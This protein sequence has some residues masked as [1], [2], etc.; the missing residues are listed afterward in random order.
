MKHTKVFLFASLVG[1]S[2]LL[3]GCEF[4]LA[5]DIT[6]PPG[7]T[8][9][10]TTS[11][12]QP[13]SSGPN[14]PLVAPNPASG[15]AIY[16]EK[17]L[18]CHGELGMGD[19]SQAAQLPNPVPAIGREDVAQQAK[20]SDWYNIVTNGNL[21]RYMPPF[22][23]LS[24][25]QRWDV[26][27]YVLSLS[28]G[29]NDLSTGAAV[30]AENCAACHGPDGQGDGRE[31]AGL[32][33]PPTSFTDQEIMAQL[34]ASDLYQSVKNGSGEMPAFGD[35]LSDDQIWAV[36]EYLRSLGFAGQPTAS[37]GGEAGGG[38]ASEQPG[39]APSGPETAAEAPGNEETD[40][41]TAS[42]DEPL[43]RVAGQVTN[44]SGGA[45]PDDLTITLHGLDHMEVVYSTTTTLAEDGTYAFDG[46]EFLENRVYVTTTDYN[47]ATYGS[48]VSIVE[49]G[50]Q[51]MD[52]PI[53]LYDTTT[54]ASVLSIDRLHMF[55]DFSQ[56]EVVQVVELYVISNPTNKTVV[57]DTDGGTVTSFTVPDGATNL[58]FQDGA[59]GD[60]YVQTPDGFADT[61]AVRP[62]QG[63]Y[64]VMYAFDMPYDRKMDLSQSFK[65]PIDAM[66]VM[67]PAEG[68]TLRSDYL[69]DS[70]TRDVQGEAF[71]MY[72]GAGLPAGEALDF[73]LSGLP[74]DTGVLSL[75][76]DATTTTSLVIGLGA[77]GLV[78]VVAGVW[79]YRRNNR[80]AVGTDEDL[81]DQDIDQ[82]GYEDAETI[83]DAIIALDDLHAAGEL[84]EEA[85]QQ[86]RAELKERLR[87]VIGE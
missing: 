66:I 73:S 85:Y 44:G 76:G 39:S 3:A 11:Q 71:Q 77:L 59:L 24:E 83:V 58:Q 4:S 9:A 28:I 32:S 86:R 75:T 37:T 53:T 80:A 78:L 60:R 47:G 18:P 6:P 17:C 34:S 67:T 43:G 42:V 27:A 14:Y 20:P 64:Q 65:L 2:L 70:G 23:S 74:G 55:F 72:T 87:T 49:P 13:V 1:I 33:V 31:A 84:P 48:D 82:D 36:S 25:G 63:Q 16:A 19:G 51:E 57:A 50:M 10:P 56:P 5:A 52:L 8:Q 62:G 69:Q 68:V 45:I 15:A 35:R 40:T 61:A 30:Y 81:L 12:A 38:S 79:L 29:E 21:E 22:T 7:I 41:G 26:I 54:D 46:V